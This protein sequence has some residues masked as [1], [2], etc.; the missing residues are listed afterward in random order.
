MLV[1]TV[2]GRPRQLQIW[3]FDPQPGYAATSLNSKHLH[4][5]LT[6]AG[7]H[8]V[9]RAAPICGVGPW[10]GVRVDRSPPPTLTARPR[11]FS[12]RTG[13]ACPRSLAK[14]GRPEYRQ[15][16]TGRWT[17]EID[18]EPQSG[19]EV[20]DRYVPQL[21]MHPGPLVELDHSDDHYWR[22]G[23]VRLG[24]VLQHCPG[25][26]VPLTAGRLP[27][28]VAARAPV[29]ATCSW[30]KRLRKLAVPAISAHLYDKS[31]GAGGVEERARLFIANHHAERRCCAGWHWVSSICQERGWVPSMSVA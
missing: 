25:D 27:A 22:W 2:R 29:T 21:G 3:L 23:T 8:L 10:A 16:F 26:K 28:E 13:P 14:L 6:P 31:A 12:A 17:L 11:S 9:R 20:V 30:R 5:C 7:Y 19:R 1:P 24:S 15:W 18:N 4:S